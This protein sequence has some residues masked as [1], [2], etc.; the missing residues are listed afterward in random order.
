MVSYQCFVLLLLFF[1]L[2]YRT[3]YRCLLLHVRSHPNFAIHADNTWNTLLFRWHPVRDFCTFLSPNR[4]QSTCL[5]SVPS[6]SCHAYRWSFDQ[7][8]SP[9]L[10]HQSTSLKHLSMW[11]GIMADWCALAEA[12][13]GVEV[14]H[15]PSPLVN[16]FAMR[17]YFSS[18]KGT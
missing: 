11:L 12:G 17:N 10:N 8:I 14:A 6:C 2:G 9:P 18:V 7:V 15:S 16:T 13:L 3:C 1:S 4:Q 5:I